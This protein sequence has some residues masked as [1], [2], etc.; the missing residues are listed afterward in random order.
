MSMWKVGVN[1]VKPSKSAK[2]TRFSCRHNSGLPG[3][4]AKILIYEWRRYRK[5]WKQ[6]SLTLKVACDKAEGCFCRKNIQNGKILAG[7]VS[8]NLVIIHWLVRE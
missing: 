7:T 8:L 1:L 3:T 4:I 6:Q 5:V 2:S